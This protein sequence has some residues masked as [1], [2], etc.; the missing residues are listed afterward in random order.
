MLFW[1]TTFPRS[2]GVFADTSTTAPMRV[3]ALHQ[4]VAQLADEGWLN[5][6]DLK[7]IPRSAIVGTVSLS[8][9]AR[10]RDQ[11]VRLLRLQVARA[12]RVSWSAV[13]DKN[14]VH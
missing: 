7:A 1:Y 5:R 14:V 11:I 3:L 6:E 8:G 9:V 10:G 2:D 12:T 4:P 13:V